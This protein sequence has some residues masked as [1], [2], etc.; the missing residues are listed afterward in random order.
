M[1]YVIFGIVVGV[2]GFLG[3]GTYIILSYKDSIRLGM[4]LR[5]EGLVVLLA[6]EDNP[7]LMSAASMLY[8]GGEILASERKEK[9]RVAA[10]LT[11]HKGGKDE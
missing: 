3:G 5:K 2:I 7:Y 4:R 1:D 6:E 11:V 8:E 9:E 10:N